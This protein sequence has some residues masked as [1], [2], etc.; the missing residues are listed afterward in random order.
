MALLGDGMN[1][2]AIEI[3]IIVMLILVNGLFAMAEIA[4]V[5]ARKTRLQQQAQEGNKKALVA[6]EL[7]NAPNQFLATIQIGITLVGIVAGAFGGATIAEK[8]ADALQQVPPLAPYGEAIGVAVVVLA[9]TYLTLVIGELVPKRLGLNNAEQV[10][11]RLAPFMRTLSRLASP[12]VRS[13]GLSTDLVLRLLGVRPGEETPVSEEEINLLLQHGTRAGVFQ[14]AEQEMVE[15]VFLLG[16]ATVKTI[17]TPRPEIV[18]LNL[19]DP[20]EELSRVVAA[21]GHSRYPVGRGDLDHVL[22]LV[23][24]KNLLAACL[25][26]KPLDIEAALQ[27]ALFLP[28]SATVLEAVARLKEKHTDAA[29]VIDEYGGLEGLI[30][31]DDIL[32]AIVGDIPTP[33]QA[34]EPGAVRRE[35]G[36]WLLDGTLPVAQVRKLLDIVSLPHQDSA[37][38]TLGGLVML[39]LQRVPSPGDRFEC[40]GWRFEVVDMD[41]R[42]VDKVLATFQN[43][44]TAQS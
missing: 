18:W 13:L 1:R 43:R 4:I 3:L 20:A 14:L 11:A 39:Y 32:R 40:C 35:D 15:Q 12:A 29:L 6:L 24:I 19:D 10:A 38:Q 31:V 28:E 37:Y 22:G 17:M 36:S 41:G 30:T 25:E 2:I 7:A 44:A 16:D 21:G 27:P 34:V 8:L 23:F 9:I 42:R 33:G 5:S 26:G